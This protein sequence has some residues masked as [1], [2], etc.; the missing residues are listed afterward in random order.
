MRKQVILLM[1]TIVFALALCGAVAASSG[2]ETSGIEAV[3]ALPTSSD[4]GTEIA[5]VDAAADTEEEVEKV[6]PQITISGFV[7]D[8]QTKLGF[9]DVTITVENNENVLATTKTDKDGSY[10]TSFTSNDTLF[11]VIASALGHIPSTTEVTVNSNPSDPTDSNL[12]GTADFELGNPKALFMFHTSIDPIFA[13]AVIDC[14]YLEGDIR[15]LTNLPDKFTDYNLVFIDWL[16]GTTKNLERIRTLMTGAIK[17]NIP[18]IVTRHW[19]TLPAEVIHAHGHPEHQWIR[20]YWINRGSVVNA[21]E[22]LKYLGDRFLGLDVGKPQAPA[23]A[24]RTGI[25]HPGT[26]QS[27][28]SLDNYLNRYGSIEGKKTVGVLFH[29]GDYRRGD[30]EAVDALIK[31]FENK[32]IKVIPYFYEHEGKPNIDKFLMRN[33]KSA[34]DAIVHYKMFGWSPKS[35]LEDVVLELKKLDVPVI[36]ASKFF[37]TYE[38]WLNGTQGIQASIIGA[39]IVPS[40]RDGMFDPIVISTKESDPKYDHL[41]FKVEFYK[42]IDRQ[43]NWIVDRTIAW[44]N[45]RYTPNPEKKVAIMY[46][47]KPGKDRGAGAGH[48]DV[49]ASLPKLL[50]ALKNEGYNLGNKSLP[51]NT[52]LVKLI[53]DQGLNIGLWA[54]GELEKLVKNY[55]VILVPLDDYMNWFNELNEAK[56]KEVIDM[57]GEPPGD[58]MVYEDKI[59]LPVIQ[60]GN[61]ILAPEPS[62]GYTQDQGALYHS[63]KIPPTHQYLAFYLWLKKDFGAN[64]AIHFGRHGTVA[65]L[66]GKTGPGLDKDNCWPAIVSQDIPVIYPFTV[67]GGE[68]LLPKRR[69]GAVMISHLTPPVTIA[70]LYGKLAILH[71][72]IHHYETTGDISVKEEYKKSIIQL[73]KDI[74]INEDLNVDLNNINNFAEFLEELHLYL[75]ELESE[76]I[77]YGLHIFGKPP[78]GDKLTHTVQSLLGYGFRDYMKNNNLSDEQVQN[79]LK[80][81]IL[82]RSTPEDAQNSVLG[83][84]FV[85]LTNYLNLAMDYVSRINQCTREIESTVNALSGR[86]IPPGMMGDPIINP[87]ILPTGTNFYSFDPREVPSEEAWRVGV[88]LTDDMIERYKKETGDY[89]KK[90]AF[91]LWATHT[92]LDKGVMEASIL[93]LLGVEPVPDKDFRNYIT[94]VKLKENLGRPRIDVVITTTA[95]YQNMYRCRL[96]LLDR[97]VRIA[98][99]ATDTLPN[100][101]RENSEAIYQAIKEGHHEE[102]ARKFSMSRVFSQ[103]PGNH[104]NAMQHALLMGGTWENEGQ[105]ASAYIG[106]FGNVHIGSDTGVRY[107][108]DLYTLN[109]GGSDIAMFRRIF[110]VNDLFGDDDYFGYFGGLGLTIKHVSDGRDPKMWLMNLENPNKPKIESLSESLWRD[111]RTQ[112]FNPKWISSMQ[113]HEAPGARKFTDFHSHLFG[114][115]VTAPDAVTNS[116]WNEAYDV[117]IK[118]KHNLGLKG[119]FGKHNSYAHQAISAQMLEAI[120]KGFWQTD[121]ATA[122][123]LANFLANS[124]AQN[125]VACGDSTC[126]NLAMMKWATSYINADILAQFNSAVYAA[127]GNPAFASAS[128]GSGVPGSGQTPGASPGQTGSPGQRSSGSGGQMSAGQGPGDQGQMSAGQSP[129]DQGQKAYEVSKSEGSG[130]SQTGMPVAA[131]AGVI[132]LICLVG[133]GYFRV[134]ILNWFRK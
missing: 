68:G 39:T 69:Q 50:E 18:V 133:V 43:V 131:I 9:P 108:P 124:V 104:R 134:D 85:D 96:D 41:P 38:E 103:E 105:L 77:P 113:D 44:I 33:G 84:V 99:N 57:W 40:E 111:V 123:E 71:N 56:K 13:V 73:C 34:V 66:P 42:P 53:R 47:H 114:W 62:R 72:K 49:Y 107:L 4:S 109:L 88:K 36:K 92:E 64:A 121:A 8:C 101:V 25:Y 65:W 75:H 76:F 54:P 23:P 86:Y 16:S 27:F 95:L 67:E 59:V 24:K 10:T 81:V 110:N 100:Y 37:R 46:W 15:L 78:E 127:T 125:G 45:L 14:D 1:I 90:I 116:M 122:T 79:L 118:D 28:D 97:A 112:Y 83:M 70:G 35:L 119:W 48:I 17:E 20:D 51:N 89:P 102:D 19:T 130:S 80:K 7:V 22:L 132:L 2:V 21:K 91:M 29:E 52:D 129:G 60:F 31:D 126:G 115:D 61:I 106:T 58:I 5:Q 6:L 12:Y 94:D 120:R 117:Y 98:A 3:Q 55:P 26:M 63:G 74:N 82:E 32:G 30:L 93:Y 87:N 11:K 128:P